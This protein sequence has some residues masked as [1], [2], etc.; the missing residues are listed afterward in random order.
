[1][2]GPL[3]LVRPARRQVRPLACRGVYGAPGGDGL[4]SLARLLLSRAEDEA[5]QPARQPEPSL[6]L[7]QKLQRPA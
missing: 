6:L 2:T 5:D 4:D 1:M 3:A 7:P